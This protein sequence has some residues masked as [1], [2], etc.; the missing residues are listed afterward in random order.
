VKIIDGRPTA[1]APSHEEFERVASQPLLCYACGL[2]CDLTRSRDHLAKA[3]A[4]HEEVRTYEERI[5]TVKEVIERPLVQMQRK[6][7]EE[8]RSREAEAIASAPPHLGAS[9]LFRYRATFEKGEEVKY[10]SHLDLTRALPRAFR[11]A[12]IRLGYSQGYHPMPLI[13]YGPALGVGTVGH[14]EL[15]DFDSADGLEEREFLDRINAVLPPGLRFKS[16]R[17]LP[18]GAPSLI[19]EV[20]RAEYSVMLD[21]PEI[22]A[23]IQ[24]VR[25]ER[26]DLA[27]MDACGIHDRLFEA[28][29]ARESCVIERV[30]K[31][32]RQRVDVRRYTKGL[33]LVEDRSSL[34]IVTEVSP[35]G[36]VKP[37]EVMA[38]VY[39]LTETETTALS[40]RVRRLRLYSENQTSDPAS[41][42]H[43]VGAA[44]MSEQGEKLRVTS[45]HS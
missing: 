2:E 5:A 22:E 13:Q 37:I 15:I 39:G 7:G 32:K 42:I 9:A 4:L 6:D 8:Q 18:A 10:L 28:F 3:Y 35:N 21:A 41:W 11:R 26:A 16:L 40:S 45:S 33:S 20:N 27:A 19:K 17:S 38:A 34:S 23:A 25:A 1:I 30:R 44:Q 43:G 36:G 12:K 31:D 29:T 24:R 14:N